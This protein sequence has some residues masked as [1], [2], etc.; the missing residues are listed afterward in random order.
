M[1]DPGV[2]ISG[3]ISSRAA[4]RE[5]LVAWHA[6]SF[7]MIVSLKLLYE[8]QEVLSRDKF[9]R[10]LSIQDVGEYVLWIEDEA[11]AA[12]DPEMRTSIITRDPKDDYLVALALSE[13]ADFLVSGDPH[14]LDLKQVTASGIEGQVR[15]LTPREFLEELERSG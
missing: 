7:E 1:L 2:L 8:L 3:A 13:S 11:T 6:G 12:A 14:L 4:P 10:Y 15:A 5:I 9:R